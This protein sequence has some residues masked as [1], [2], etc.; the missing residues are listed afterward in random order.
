MM[1]TQARLKQLLRY[2]R[3][4]GVFYWRIAPP[5]T[6]IKAG[7]RAGCVDVAGYWKI[8]LEGKQ[9]YGHRLAWLYVYGCWPK[10][11]KAIDH[12]NR[13]KTDNRI[14]NLREA[15]SEERRVGKER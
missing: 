9:Y 11:P 6:D 2:D 5:R 12:K 4:S 15:R 13:I 8:Q 10:R 3:R 7:A 1:L 14:A